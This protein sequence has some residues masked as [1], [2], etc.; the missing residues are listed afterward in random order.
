MT[1]EKM[2]KEFDE[3]FVEKDYDWWLTYY[4]RDEETERDNAV[5]PTDIKNFIEKVWH[6]SLESALEDE[7]IGMIVQNCTGYTEVDGRKLWQ[8][9]LESFEK[10]LK[11]LSTPPDTEPLEGDNKEV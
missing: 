4:E 8:L 1:L 6:A 2:L 5:T 7:V 10:D 3:K 9:D 11:A